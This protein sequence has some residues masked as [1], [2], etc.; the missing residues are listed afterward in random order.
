IR[1]RDQDDLFGDQLNLS[2]TKLIGRDSELDLA[3]IRI[4]K[5]SDKGY[6]AIDLSK[7]ASA[8]VGETL[9]GVEKMGKYFDRTP[10]IVPTLIGGVTKKPRELYIPTPGAWTESMFVGTP[11][12]TGA[13]E[14]VGMSV[15]QMPNADSEDGM[16]AKGERITRFDR[17]FK[18]LPASELAAATARALEAEKSGKAVGMEE[19][20]KEG[21]DKK[22]DANPAGEKKA[23]EPKKEP[24]KKD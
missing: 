6:S 12:F 4:D 16:R 23:E 13:G 18:I 15:I 17:G 3:W 7:S 8:K 24:A 9:V 10:V 2:H 5:P 19:P 21:E 1:A 14:F 22:E 20:K 11:Y